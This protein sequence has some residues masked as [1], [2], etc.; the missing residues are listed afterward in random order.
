MAGI[1]SRDATDAA[2][3]ARLEALAA[4]LA[5]RRAGY[6]FVL[7]CNDRLGI[8]RYAE[9][10][11]VLR[12]SFSPLPTAA[13]SG[14]PGSST[15]LRR[16][17]T[18][19]AAGLPAI[20]VLDD[21]SRLAVVLR[22]LGLVTAASVHVHATAHRAVL[23][24]VRN[25]GRFHELLPLDRTFATYRLQRRG[26][27]DTEVRMRGEPPTEVLPATAGEHAWIESVDVGPACPLDLCVLLGMPAALGT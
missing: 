4:W 14:E 20:G 16:R 22:S 25:A 6:R 11:R 5:A 8:A 26:S 17:R 21:P 12:L 15:L 2:V 3:V 19:G 27:V 9:L 23:L 13:E 24:E 7:E 10:S 18:D 1:A